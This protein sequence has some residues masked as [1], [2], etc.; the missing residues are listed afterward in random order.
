MLACYLVK[1]KLVK[2]HPYNTWVP[3]HPTT[4]KKALGQNVHQEIYLFHDVQHSFQLLMLSL[5][6]TSLIVLI[7]T[8]ASMLYMWVGRGRGGEGNQA[9][10]FEKMQCFFTCK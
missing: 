6:P 10:Y 9:A 3:Q 1:T 5:K 8:I 2:I 4:I 7:T